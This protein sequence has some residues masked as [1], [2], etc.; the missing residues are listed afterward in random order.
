MN[1]TRPDEW[2]SD[3]PSGPIVHFARAARAGSHVLIGLYGFSGCGKTL[4]AIYL[5]RGLAGP[6]GKVGMIDTE[7]GRGL[8]YAMEGG[9]YE[10]AELTPP[11]TPERYTEAIKCAEQAGID[12]L[13]ID[14]GS[15]VWEGIGGVLEMAEATNQK[16]LVKWAQPKA[17]Y[18]RYVNA[19]LNTRMH[20]IICL[21][22]KERMVQVTRD[23]Q[24]KYPGAK[25]GDIMS[26]GM[27]AIQEKRFIYEMTVQAFLP[28]PGDGGP[29]GVPILEKCPKDLLG[30]F[31]QHRQISVQTGERIR[32]WVDGGVPVDHTAAEIRRTAEEQAER[33][34]D[35]MRAWWNGL[36]QDER[37]KLEPMLNNLRSI[38]ATADREA[39][40]RAAAVAA[41]GDERGD[42]NDR[43]KDPFGGGQPTPP[44]AQAG[45]TDTEAGGAPK[46]TPA[47]AAGDVRR[48]AAPSGQPPRQPPA[49]K[50]APSL[51]M[52]NP[53]PINPTGREQKAWADAAIAAIATA[54]AE[55]IGKFQRRCGDT[56][57]YFE[58]RNVTQ[59]ERL[60]EAINSRLTG[61]D[62][63]GMA[64]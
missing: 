31:P 52:L 53:L 14:S 8:I 3:A 57:E 37:R 41:S 6:D 1:D 21:R 24:A 46:P 58:G 2:R 5:A 30:A 64:V 29:R 40:E 48:P 51:D 42:D 38:A 60:F 28:V 19:M 32:E 45:A 43:F 22:A 39:E 9:G 56:I 50:S 61:G 55:Q 49:G 63:P 13:I 15:H 7:T 26:D 54:T 47:P 59:H 33:G 62:Q 18:K 34:T 17:R 4:S 20:I 44:P 35:A 16:G 36:A 12:V 23:N 11:F 25:I 10:Y 27:V